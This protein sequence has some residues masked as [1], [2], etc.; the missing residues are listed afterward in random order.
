MK[1]KMV[2][3]VMCVASGS[4]ESHKECGVFSRQWSPNQRTRPRTML[5]TGV[6]TSCII[7]CILQEIGMPVSG[8]MIYTD[9]ECIIGIM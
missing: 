3:D 8:Y 9:H 6:V 5:L 4:S 1:F 7:F 2:K